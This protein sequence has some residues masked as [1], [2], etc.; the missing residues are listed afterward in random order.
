MSKFFM[1]GGGA[2]NLDEVED[3]ERERNSITNEVVSLCVTFKSGRRI[4][5]ECDGDTAYDIL[6]Q[7]INTNDGGS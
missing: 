4:S 5:E 3:I 7:I 2:I 1:F 6:K